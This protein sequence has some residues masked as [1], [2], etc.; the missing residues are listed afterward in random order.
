MQ[1]RALGTSGPE[2]SVVGFGAWEAGGTD[3]GPNESDE[4]VVE[5]MRAAIDAGMT[6][7]DTAEVYGN[8][9]SEELV[10]RALE[11]R[12][13]E[14]LVFT[15]VAPADEG[16][17]LRPEEIGRAVRGSL[18][19]L[20]IDHV[21][22]Y[23]VHWP[24][25]RIP[26][27]D[28]WGAMAELQDEGLA[29]YIGVSNFDREL[30]ERCLRI[31]AV[32]S[33]Q[34]E[35]SLVH[36]QDRHALLPWLDEQGIGYLAYSPLG[37]GML[38]GAVTSGTAF[39]EAD[40][41]S[42]ERRGGGEIFG[43]GTFERNVEHVEVLRKVAERLGTDLAPLALRWALDQRGVTAV[44]AGTRSPKHS[45]ANAVAGALELDAAVLEEIDT[46]FD[47]PERPPAT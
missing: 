24:D 27:E 16:S 11:G 3:W 13:D 29:R 40:W 39:A 41:R 37:A 6:W 19:R 36:Q 35:F 23:Q 2:I 34:N 21:D 18:S 4:G 1:M 7:I 45:R 10:S 32:T 31:R 15:K 30:I 5:S 28:S 9:H 46:I 43:P 44:I 33:V 25:S 14:V 12:R 26:V 20:R 17:G 47:A 42:E 22:L 8:G 38:T